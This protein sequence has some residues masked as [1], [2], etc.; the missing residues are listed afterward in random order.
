M[1]INQLHAAG[2]NPDCS[3]EVED[4]DEHNEHN[5]S[6]IQQRTVVNS[7]VFAKT[8]SLQSLEK[9]NKQI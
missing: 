6:S 3:M 5:I 8:T 9:R 7:I 2:C 1:K 4:H